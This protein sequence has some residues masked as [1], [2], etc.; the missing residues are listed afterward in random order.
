VPPQETHNC[1]YISRLLTKPWEYGQRMLRFYDFETDRFG[2]KS[3]RSMFAGERLNTPNVER[4]LKDYVEDPLGAIRAR[5]ANGDVFP[6]ENDWACHRA[7]L[8]MVWLQG[9]RPTTLR[10]QT[11]REWLESL[12]R[13]PEAELNGLVMLMREDHDLRLIHTVASPTGDGFAPLYFPSTG[14]FP[15]LVRDPGCLSGWSFALGLPIDVH[16][17]LLVT[18]TERHVELDLAAVRGMLAS[19]SIGLSRAL[20]VVIAPALYDQEGEGRL[21]ALLHELRRT[22]DHLVDLVQQCRQLVASAFAEFGLE[23]QHDGAGR[24]PPRQR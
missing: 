2:S 13:M 23:P 10:E 19:W 6:L 4:W 11:A 8:L 20:R 9:G 12:A 18:P 1:H 7:A 14:L 21:R 17:A 24:I 15:F 22:N 5:I 16:C 3:S